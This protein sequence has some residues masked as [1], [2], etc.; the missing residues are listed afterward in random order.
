MDGGSNNLDR[1]NE[2]PE[3]DSKGGDEWTEE[4]R[5]GFVGVVTREQVGS[6]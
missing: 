5:L 2:D 4:G 6:L 1:E 3:G